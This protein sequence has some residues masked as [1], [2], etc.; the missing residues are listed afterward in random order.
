ML[1]EYAINETEI[2]KAVSPYHKVGTEKWG[3]EIVPMIFTGD[4]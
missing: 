1:F 2:S 3:R 4:I